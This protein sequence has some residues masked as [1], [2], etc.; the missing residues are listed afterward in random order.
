MFLKGGRAKCHLFHY[1]SSYSVFW[2]S[3]LFLS[4]LLSLF[5][6]VFVLNPRGNLENLEQWHDIVQVHEPTL[7]CSYPKWWILHFV[8]K[9]CS[10]H[11]YLTKYVFAGKNWCSYIDA[12]ANRLDI[13]HSRNLLVFETIFSHRKSAQFSQGLARL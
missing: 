7:H 6:Y 13:I 11:N 3:I 8:W 2:Y 4:C 10:M 5:T 9:S 12:F 1:I